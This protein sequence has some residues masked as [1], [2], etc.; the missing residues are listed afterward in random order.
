MVIH[1]V[2]SF[3]GGQEEPTPGKMTFY[4]KNEH[5]YFSQETFSQY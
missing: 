2:L 4:I 1:K 3:I 5:L